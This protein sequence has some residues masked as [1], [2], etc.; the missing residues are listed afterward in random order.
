MCVKVYGCFLFWFLNL[1]RR[2][3]ISISCAALAAG[4]S[5]E[6]RLLSPCRI[7]FPVPPGVGGWG[8]AG[9][10]RSNKTRIGP[11]E[12]SSG[13]PLLTST[14]SSSEGEG[15][16]GWCPKL[17]PDVPHPLKQSPRFLHLAASEQWT[18]RSGVC[19][20]AL[21]FGGG[22]RRGYGFRDRNVALNH[23]ICLLASAAKALDDCG[24]SKT[25]ETTFNNLHWPQ[26][27]PSS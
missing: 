20:A 13:F 9:A 25:S 1:H 11:W 22:G 5:V 2:W 15:V 27:C 12:Q 17:S 23:T 16:T 26:L 24:K 6:F 14:G 3:C 10:S 19:A 4:Q 7:A 8:P 21:R 18:K